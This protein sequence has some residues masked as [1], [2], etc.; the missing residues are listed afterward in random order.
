M[1]FLGLNLGGFIAALLLGVATYFYA[2][3]DYLIMLF[4]FLLLSLY[5]TSMGYR[6]KVKLGIYDYERGIPNVLSN[7][8]VPVLFAVSGNTFAFLGSVAAITADKF[9]SELGVL[10]KE[11]PVELFTWRKV[12]K[13]ASGAVTLL[14]TFASFVGSLTVSFVSLHFFPYDPSQALLIAVAG[15]IGGLADTVAGFFEERGIG[16]KETSNLVCSVVGGLLAIL[17]I[18]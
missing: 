17:S 7:G 14:G 12:K 9:G 5:I 1:G 10:G 16:T 15:F 13:G 11:R 6:Y 8:V 3:I 2:G 18:G 4:V